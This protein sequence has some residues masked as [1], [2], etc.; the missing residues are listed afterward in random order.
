M[1]DSN[2][3][4]TPNYIDGAY[5]TLGVGQSLEHWSKEGP[6][7]WATSRDYAYQRL[8]IFSGLGVD[9]N[10]GSS[11]IASFVPGTT[12][13]VNQEIW[14]REQTLQI[15]DWEN[16]LMGNRRNRLILGTGGDGVNSVYPTGGGGSSYKSS[17]FISA[18]YSDGGSWVLNI[19]NDKAIN[20]SFNR[21]SSSGPDCWQAIR[22]NDAST[23]A[24][25]RPEAQRTRLHIGADNDCAWIKGTAADGFTHRIK[26]MA[27]DFSGGTGLLTTGTKIATFDKNGVGNSIQWH[28]LNSGSISGGNALFINTTTDEM[29]Y[30]ISTRKIK[31]NITDTPSSFVDAILNV[32]TVRF[33]QVGTPIDSHIYGFIAEELAEVHTS[34][35]VWGLDHVYQ[36]GT[37]MKAAALVDTPPELNHNGTLLQSTDIVPVGVSDRALLAAAIAKIQDLEVR[38]KV[39]ETA[40]V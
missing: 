27:G 24:G 9:E 35:A 3:F 38:L 7:I 17:S 18:T 32:R 28:T 21:N 20:T 22:Q 2:P 15:W 1:A 40:S 26:F 37:T 4:W 6:G 8:N 12:G 34:F 29:I 33:N 36:P 25:I 30:D 16:G 23:D 39:L 11:L 31:E 10:A 14:D 19:M 13:G 5:V